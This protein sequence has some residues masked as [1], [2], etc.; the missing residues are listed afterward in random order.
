MLGPRVLWKKNQMYKV[1][2]FSDKRYYCFDWDLNMHTTPT[3]THTNVIE[4]QKVLENLVLIIL[5][6]LRK[7][8]DS[9]YVHNAVVPHS[10]APYRRC[11]YVHFVE[12]S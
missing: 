5:V 11:A 9:E 10:R 12:A 3:C 8:L 1:R 7:Q 6:T 4:V 2:C